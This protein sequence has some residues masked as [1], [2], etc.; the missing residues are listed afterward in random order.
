MVESEVF[1]KLGRHP[2]LLKRARVILKTN[3]LYTYISKFFPMIPKVGFSVDWHQDNFYI[4]ADP[5][6]LIS[7]DVFVNGAT[8]ENGCLRIAPRSHTK[9]R[10]QLALHVAHFEDS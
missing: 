4:K 3:D 8:K 7:C 2:E 10:V 1:K 6:K 9:A 5:T